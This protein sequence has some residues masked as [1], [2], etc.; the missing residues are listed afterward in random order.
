V[1][2]YA[3]PGT[4]KC[5]GIGVGGINLYNGDA[6]KSCKG[7]A[8]TVEVDDSTRIATLSQTLPPLPVV[9][10]MSKISILHGP[11]VDGADM[12]TIGI[13]GMIGG[14]IVRVVISS[15]GQK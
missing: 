5:E 3:T 11:M 8:S 4:S 9:P 7:C 15:D 14:E 6:K 12:A 2:P 1:N 13:S 10:D